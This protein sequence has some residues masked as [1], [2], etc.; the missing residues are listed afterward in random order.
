M[1][2]QTRAF[3]NGAKNTSREPKYTGKLNA[4]RRV[5]KIGVFRDFRATK[6]RT[7][8]CGNFP[9]GTFFFSVRNFVS[10]SRAKFK[11]SIFEL[12]NFPDGL[13]RGLTFV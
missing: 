5:K 13:V 10:S 8:E 2:A 11:P 12:P 4:E 6:F 1:T 3:E 9:D 7:E